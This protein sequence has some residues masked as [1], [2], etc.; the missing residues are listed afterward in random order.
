MPPG[1][2]I[3][4]SV[5]AFYDALQNVLS[6]PPAGL[7]IPQAGRLCKAEVILP[8]RLMAKRAGIRP[9]KLCIPG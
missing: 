1:F 7:R 9:Q 3:P 4:G 5:V 8:A 2:A 6:F